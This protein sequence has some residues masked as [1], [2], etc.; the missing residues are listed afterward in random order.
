MVWSEEAEKAVAAVPFFIRKRVRGYVEKEAQRC[1][2]GRVLIEHVQACRKRFLSGEAMETK[3][4]Q[5]ETCFGAS[6]CPNRAAESE[7]VVEKLEKLFAGRR[8]GEALA[9]RVGG[10]IRMHHEFR[11]SVSDCPNACSRPQ[12][13]DIGIIGA[14]RPGLFDG[15]CNRC[16]ACVNACR[17]G[18]LQ[19][20]K[21]AG[22]PVLHLDRCVLCGKCS[23]VC[24][25][26]SIRNFEKG[27]RIL[28][29]GKL[30]RHPQLGRELDG[31]F[32]EAEVIGTVE[33]CLD[34]YFRHGEGG[35]RFGAVLNRL[36]WEVLGKDGA[37]PT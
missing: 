10:A 31:I 17:E 29:G 37:L 14:R 13:V 12:I 11:V 28:V 3:G 35:E 34:V 23:S 5:I 1:G 30:G 22:A 32:S 4:Y 20:P 21:A 27:Y 18:A 26:K 16:G 33:R 36:G 9:A 24:P 2:A 8:F 15:N 7:R 19:H 6:G 25:T